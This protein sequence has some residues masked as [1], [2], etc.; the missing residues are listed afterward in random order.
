MSRVV[1]QLRRLAALA[2]SGCAVLALSVA[3]HA[4]TFSIT[5]VTKNSASKASYPNMVVDAN[6]NLN[7]IWVDSVNGIMFARSSTTAGVTTLGT[8]VQVTGSMGQRFPLSSRK[9]P[10]ILT[11]PALS[12]LPGRRL[13]PPRLRA[14]PPSTTSMP[15][16]P[17]PAACSFS[18]TAIS[19]SVSPTGLPLADS[20]RLAFDTGG[21]ANIVWGQNAAWIIQTPNGSFFTP[22]VNLSTITPP[23]TINTGGPRVAVDASGEVV[24]VWTD[25][26][27]GGAPGTY[28]TKPPNPPPDNAIIGGNFWV[29]ETLP[30]AVVGAPYT[31]NS[32][33]TRNLS[34]TD[35]VPT[36][37]TDN[38][39]RFAK[40]F[41]GCSFDNLRLFTDK[42]GHVNLLWSD[43]SPI[44]DVLTSKP[45][46]GDALT[47]FAFPINLA[48]VPAASPQVA[49]DTKGSILCGLV[50]R[51]HR[52][53]GTKWH[54]KFPGHFL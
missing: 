28:C 45:V 40:G 36:A 25:I 30:P 9:L 11:T 46:N 52:R 14:A 48:T 16:G 15:A 13:I 4:Q 7:L 18:T 35:W 34:A 6:G 53:H 33:N 44:E 8:A 20:P 17:I 38:A 32:S 41:F 54:H 21:R 24:V 5:N 51:P 2:I 31:F 19:V 39:N 47:N 49:V 3:A 23:A 37:G 10:S 42:S 29:N 12:P 1:S 50:R 26:A 43:E 22:P 27:N